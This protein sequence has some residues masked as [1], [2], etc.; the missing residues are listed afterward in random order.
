MIKNYSIVSPNVVKAGLSGPGIKLYWMKI[1]KPSNILLY[2]WHNV[3]MYFAFQF[4]A[5]MKKCAKQADIQ[6]CL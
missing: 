1:S 4:S 3:V 6:K 5:A 2:P